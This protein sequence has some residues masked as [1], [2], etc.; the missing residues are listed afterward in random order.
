MDAAPRD[1]SRAAGGCVADNVSSFD[2]KGMGSSKRVLGSYV[3]TSLCRRVDLGHGGRES[4]VRS[5][6]G[7]GA[8]CRVRQSLPVMHLYQTSRLRL[9]GCGGQRLVVQMPFLRCPAAQGQSNVNAGSRML[10]KETVR[11]TSSGDGWWAVEMTL[12][13]LPGWDRA[14]CRFWTIS[15]TFNRPN[16]A[17]RRESTLD[18]RQMVDS[19]EANGA[20]AGFE[21]SLASW[22][23]HGKEA[24]GRAAGNLPPWP[25]HLLVVAAVKAAPSGALPTNPQS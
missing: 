23:W 22:Q 18:S 16:G 2:N 14:R 1:A 3:F 13:C 19:N 17:S 24:G 21:E 6:D 12:R 25:G 8:N 10:A 15:G 4:P 20:V 5:R 11:Q 7:G 9:R